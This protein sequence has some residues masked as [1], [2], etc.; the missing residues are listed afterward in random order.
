MEFLSNVR[1]SVQ[2]LTCPAQLWN[3]PNDEAGSAGTRPLL[4]LEG[5]GTLGTWLEASVT[6]EEGGGRT[7]CCFVCFLEDLTPPSF[8]GNRT[9]NLLWLHESLLWQCSLPQQSHSS[10]LPCFGW[11]GTMYFLCTL[12]RVWQQGLHSCTRTPWMRCGLPLCTLKGK[13]GGRKG[14]EPS[15]GH[16]TFASSDQKVSEGMGSAQK[17]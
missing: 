11:A 5:P 8:H 7:G 14:P 10:T 12:H 15:P 3:A 9:G 17:I 13:E 2:K 6:R 16:L 1:L 4:C